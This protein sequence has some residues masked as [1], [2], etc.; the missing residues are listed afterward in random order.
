MYSS[1]IAHT[2][3]QNK[4]RKNSIVLTLILIIK[5]DP[6][7]LDLPTTIGGSVY[8]ILSRRVLPLLYIIHPLHI[9]IPWGVFLFQHPHEATTNLPKHKQNVHLE[10][11]LEM[12]KIF[13]ITAD[14][15]KE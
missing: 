1:C 13:Y 5:L 8:T 3:N 2:S 6:E 15:E 12:Y 10:Q 7:N 11:V 4:R 14:F 9:V